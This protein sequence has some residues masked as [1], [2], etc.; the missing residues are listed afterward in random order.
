MNHLQTVE[1]NPDAIKKS[2]QVFGNG[3]VFSFTGK[4]RN[5]Q[6]GVYSA[7]ATNPD[8]A[9]ILKFTDKV[10]VVTPENPNIFVEQIRSSLVNG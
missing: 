2:T 3:G 4:F 9:V 1:I 6:L 10:I 5:E 7:Y 8:L